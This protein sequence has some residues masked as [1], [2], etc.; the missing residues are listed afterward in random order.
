MQLNR[1]LKFIAIFIGFIFTG[2]A[3]FEPG[4]RFHDLTRVR[5]PTV[6]EMLEGLEVSVEEFASV[7]KSQQAFDTDLASYGVLALL[8]RLENK[9]TENYHVHQQDIQAFLGNH[10][11]PFLSGI[12]AASRAAT[13]EYVGK[14]L[15]WTVATGPFFIFLWPATIAGSASHTQSVNQR[16]QQHFEGLMF[17]GTLLKP[18]QTA[19]GFLYFRL[20]DGIKNLEKLTLEV[21][22]SEERSGRRPTFKLSLPTLQLSNPASSSAASETRAAE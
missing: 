3:S 15:G 7:S 18:N 11:L 8:V 4:L 14:A 1:K 10:P 12:E 21:Q 20:P 9:G 17:N 2:C 22:V 5:Q 16:I 6:K 13:S 19:A